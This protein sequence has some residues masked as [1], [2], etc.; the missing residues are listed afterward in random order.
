MQSEMKESWSALL[1][2]AQKSLQQDRLVIL[3]E[4]KAMLLPEVEAMIEQISTPIVEKSRA[5][6]TEEQ[7]R[8]LEGQMQ[9]ERAYL[10]TTMRELVQ[11]QLSTLSESTNAEL[12]RVMA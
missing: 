9:N 3:P 11:Q 1:T 2:E 4:A 8:I 7:Q 5:A 10:L 12:V 6:I